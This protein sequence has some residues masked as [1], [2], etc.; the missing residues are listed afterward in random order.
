HIWNEFLYGVTFTTGQQQ[1]VTA[2]LIALSAA[3]ADIPRHGVQTAAGMIAALPTLLI[4]L[5]AG[6]AF[7]RGGAAG[8]V[9][10]RG[11]HGRVKHSHSLEA[12][13]QSGGAEEHQS[14]HRE[15]RV[16]RAGRT[17]RLRQV[18]SPQHRRGARSSERRRRR[19]R[20]PRR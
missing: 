14:R 2:A 11:S 4:Y 15:R 8:A 20:R 16:Y 10:W 1:P 18:H 19:D 3:D 6:K 7:G 13:R 9:T 12:V 5:I 17:V